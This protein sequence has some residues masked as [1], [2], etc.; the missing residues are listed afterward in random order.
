MG[1]FAVKQFSE[2]TYHSIL[3]FYRAS[4]LFLVVDKIK[5]VLLYLTENKYLP[6]VTL[7][8]S[9]SG[10]G[11]IVTLGKYCSLRSAPQVFLIIVVS[12]VKRNVSTN[13]DIIVDQ[14]MMKLALSG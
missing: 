14:G 1:F 3:S 9:P 4:I 12:P 6:W 10:L 5:K 11:D 13:F 8:T 7:I 2:R